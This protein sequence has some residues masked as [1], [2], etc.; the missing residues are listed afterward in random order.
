MTD[1]GTYLT[2]LLTYLPY[3]EVPCLTLATYF[4]RFKLLPAAITY[5]NPFV[6]PLRWVTFHTLLNCQTLNVI[7]SCRLNAAS[8]TPN[9]GDCGEVAIT[10]R[11]VHLTK[12]LDTSPPGHMEC[13][14]R[15]YRVTGDSFD[16]H[17]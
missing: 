10:P 14:T 16:M 5:L 7:S 9:K 12:S 1:L 8:P 11:K 2:L 13:I 15:S 4:K 6:E 17:A 3:T